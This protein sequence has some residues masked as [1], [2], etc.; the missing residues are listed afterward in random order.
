MEK[1]LDSDQQRKEKIDYWVWHNTQQGL[2]NA[3][4]DKINSFLVKEDNKKQ[5]THK[6]YNYCNTH[7]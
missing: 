1:S 5:G 2:E 3:E 7:Q 6:K 4:Q